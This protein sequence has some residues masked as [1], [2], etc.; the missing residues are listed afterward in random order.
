MNIH[1]ENAWKTRK[2]QDTLSQLELEQ[3]VEYQLFSWNWWVLLAF[4]ITPWIVW[5]KFFDRKRLI[6]LLLVGCLVAI[7]IILL[8]A[9]GSFY[10]F[11]MYPI[12]LVPFTIGSITFDS[13]IVTVT[14]MLLYQYFKSWKSYSIVLVT[15]ALVF[16]FIGEPLAHFF[17]WVYYINWNYLYSFIIYIVLGMILKFA[18][19]NF[20]RISS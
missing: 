20:K 6:E 17:K 12:E 13:S 2:V 10:K 15:M 9:I 11:W 16:S 5:I 3:W 14:F 8:D 1:L 19:D 4:V 18:V 7:P